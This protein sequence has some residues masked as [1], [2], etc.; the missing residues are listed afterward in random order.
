MGDSYRARYARRRVSKVNSEKIDVI[1][2]VKSLHT[3]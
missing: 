2:S 1:V 3:N